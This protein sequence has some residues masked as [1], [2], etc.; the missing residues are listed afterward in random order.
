MI[1]DDSGQRV[2]KDKEEKKGLE[3]LWH[4]SAVKIGHIIEFYS[5]LF[6]FCTFLVPKLQVHF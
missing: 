3:K 4:T 6:Y 5:V 1:D 2:K